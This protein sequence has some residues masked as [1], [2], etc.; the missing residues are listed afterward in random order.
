MI[1]ILFVLALITANIF[2]YAL[3][4]SNTYVYN[5]KTYIL[6]ENYFILKLNILYI[7]FT[8]FFVLTCNI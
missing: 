4:E 6:W 7:I 8:V 5:L 2:C 3:L 1:I